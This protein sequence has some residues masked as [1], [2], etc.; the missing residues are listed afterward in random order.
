MK[1]NDIYN[2]V[3][4]NV[5]PEWAAKHTVINEQYREQRGKCPI[6]N[7]SDGNCWQSCMYNL[8]DRDNDTVYCSYPVEDG[9]PE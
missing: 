2:G 3:I 6:G 4:T 9:D 8:V 1:K 7:A 5:T